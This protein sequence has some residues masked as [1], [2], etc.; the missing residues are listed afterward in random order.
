MYELELQLIKQ[1]LEVDRPIVHRMPSMVDILCIGG[2]GYQ[3]ESN[4]KRE[5]PDP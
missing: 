1:H 4:G 2:D 3:R 5:P